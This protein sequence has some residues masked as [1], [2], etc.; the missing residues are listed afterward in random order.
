M[1]SPSAEPP[2][3]PAVYPLMPCC[4]SFAECLNDYVTFACLVTGYFPVPVEIKWNIDQGTE[5]VTHSFPPIKHSNGH[6]TS[7]SQLSIPA[8]NVE[9]NSFQCTVEHNPTNTMTS[10]MIPT[11]ERGWA[12][13]VR[14]KGLEQNCPG[15]C[16]NEGQVSK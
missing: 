7:S 13:R 11:G 5:N 1:L 14:L 12:G 2:A 15:D 4:G 9:G 10:K 6:L 3:S 8:R 16:L